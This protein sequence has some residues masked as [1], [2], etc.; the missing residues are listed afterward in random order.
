M[1]GL[2]LGARNLTD[3][4][5][6]GKVSNINQVFAYVHTYLFCSKMAREIKAIK[7]STEQDANTSTYCRL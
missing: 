4:D 2:S 1:D 7:T 3:V 5:L 6:C